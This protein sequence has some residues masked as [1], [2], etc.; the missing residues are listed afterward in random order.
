MRVG[1]CACCF[2]VAALTW[3]VALMGVVL[4]FAVRLSYYVA[5]GDRAGVVDVVLGEE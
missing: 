4:C 1:L 3:V 5:G 2:T